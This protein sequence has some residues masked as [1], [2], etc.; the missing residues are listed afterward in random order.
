MRSSAFGVLSLL[1]VACS[2]GAS[3]ETA[4][5]PIVGGTAAEPNEYPWMVALFYG[6]NTAGWY[7][8]CGGSLIDAT[9]VLTAAH[10]AT[11][12]TSLDARGAPVDSTH[13]V[14]LVPTAPESVRVAIRPQ[15]I[16]ALTREDLLPVAKVF[17]HPS[18]DDATLDS[19]LAV[20]ELARP[21]VLPSYARLAPIAEVDALV[22][23]RH[24]ARVAGYGLTAPNGDEASD[25]LKKV[26]VPLVPRA[27]CLDYY[28]RARASHAASSAPRGH[29][30]GILPTRA[31]VPT[32]KDDAPIT[33]NMICAAATAD[34]QDSCQGDSGGPLFEDGPTPRLLGVVSWGDGCAQPNVPGVYTNVSR[35][36]RWIDE[37]RQSA[38]DA[39][40]PKRRCADGYADCDADA[41]NGCERDLLAKTSCGTTCDAPACAAAETCGLD[42][43]GAPICTPATT[44]EP[45]VE[46]VYTAAD[47][48]ML[49]S[50]GYANASPYALRV[51]EPESHFE[52]VEKFVSGAPIYLLPGTL[53]HAPVARLTTPGVGS[54]T[55]KAPTGEI[56]TAT[57]TANTPVCA[58]DPSAGPFETVAPS[59]L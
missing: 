48:S 23:S 11:D 7:Q 41:A 58:T 36:S 37:C 49:V 18:Y 32:T 3:A 5:A 12:V 59:A 1:L 13:Q 47:G 6:D 8:A 27:D 33:T 57:V 56:T 53:S 43:T 50:F 4:E 20:L 28:S 54:W 17:V 29:S 39:L 10:C 55:L 24:L 15:S 22:S 51:S 30:R 38:C 25:V 26:D 19:D 52:G 16:G 35:F 42:A 34:G 40:T 21:V 46:C 14:E 44:L 31:V 45:R 9:H 2:V